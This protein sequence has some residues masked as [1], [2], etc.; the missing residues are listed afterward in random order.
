MTRLVVWSAVEIC[1]NTVWE[2]IIKRWCYKV[3]GGGGGGGGEM[4]I[5][6]WSGNVLEKRKGGRGGWGAY[7]QEVSYTVVLK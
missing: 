2:I 1:L 3:E 7:M 6:K 5:Y 4:G